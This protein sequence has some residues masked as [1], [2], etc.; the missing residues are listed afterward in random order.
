VGAAARAG[1]VAAG[2][3]TGGPKCATVAVMGDDDH[4]HKSFGGRLARAA[5][6]VFS[7]AVAAVLVLNSGPGC[8]GPK[9]EATKPAPVQQPATPAAA[10]TPA[11]V[12]PA[13]VQAAEPAPV[14][15]DSKTGPGTDG[16]LRPNA[17][18]NPGNAGNGS[19]R[20]FPASKSGVFIERNEPAEPPAKEPAVQ[21][22]A[23]PRQA[24]Q[25]QQGSR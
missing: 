7:G 4:G 18:D 12:E 5:A 16:L 2:A 23:P 14:P 15:A 1:A 22:N 17:A 13:P 21:E 24:P 19:P 3:E 6:L 9:T 8:D 25:Q 20:Y 11:P 10:P